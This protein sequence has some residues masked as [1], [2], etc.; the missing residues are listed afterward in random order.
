MPGKSGES[1]LI[2]RVTSTDPDEQMP[3]PASKKPRAS[4]EMAAKL[5]RWIDEGAK[6][7]THWAY[8]APNRP[9]VPER[10]N[11]QPA[12]WSRN[13]DRPL[14]RRRPRAT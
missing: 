2:A 10:R 9:A 5:R 13:R 6:Y 1:P 8:T 4:P 7:E 3:P 14:R 12:D 11:D